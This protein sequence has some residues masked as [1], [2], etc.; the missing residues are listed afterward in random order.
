[1]KTSKNTLRIMIVVSWLI[2]LFVGTLL[3]KHNI[4][5]LFI[6]Y[7]I[8]VTI[9]ALFFIFHINIISDFLND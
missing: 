6:S 1:M 3:F 7:M 2:S 4:V 9:G 8:G 5:A